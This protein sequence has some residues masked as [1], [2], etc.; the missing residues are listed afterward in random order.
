ML[1][2]GISDQ[3][4][5]A[6][7]VY[8]HLDF[9]NISSEPCTMYGYPDVTFLDQSREQI[10]AS[11]RRI[12]GDAAVVTID[13]GSSAMAT[14]IRRSAYVATTEGCQPADASTLQVWPPDQSVSLLIP[15][16]A[17]ACANPDTDGSGEIGVITVRTIPPRPL[18]AEPPTTTLPSPIA[19]F[20]PCAT[21]VLSAALTD[22]EWA[23]GTEYSHLTFTNTSSESCTLAGHPSVAFL[24]GRRTQIGAAVPQVPGEVGV[25]TLGP[26]SSAAAVFALHTAY[27]GTVAGCEP[28]QAT[29]LRVFPPNASTYGY[30]IP[31]S[32]RVCA[33]PSTDG[34]ASI[35]VVTD[36]TTPTPSTPAVP[37]LNASSTLDFGGLGPVRFGMT[38]AEATAAAGV[39]IVVSSGTAACSY[40]TA[41]G[42]P[43]G[44]AFMLADGRIVRVDVE[45]GSPVKTSSGAGIGDTEAHVQALYAE[46]LLVTPAKYIVAGHDL[47][48][49]PN[50]HG[51]AAFRLVFETNGATVTAFRSGQLPEVGLVER[52]G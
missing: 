50:E 11:A 32:S 51:D 48:L 39:P 44:V 22:T 17:R 7:S 10:G 24:D 38:A 2:L 49:V 34:S 20:S 3:D 16:T 31:T 25:V 9:R 41:V 47:T 21:A 23:A 19:P 33:N 40:A 1:S 52:C 42:G 26:G 43:D 36:T 37:T 46:G 35:T 30:L 15:T 28:T 29:E 6:G 5:A 4:A 27:V 45:A 12:A 8:A 13:P 18:P 14:F